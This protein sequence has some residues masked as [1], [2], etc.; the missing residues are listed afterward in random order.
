MMITNGLSCHCCA[1]RMSDKHLRMYVIVFK[2]TFDI[3]CTGLIIG[4]NLSY[5]RL[6]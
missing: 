4:I 3:Y 5:Q 1:L 2:F 6:L